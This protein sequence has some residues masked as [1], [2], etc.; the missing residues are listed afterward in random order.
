MDGALRCLAPHRILRLLNAGLSSS[1]VAHVT[2]GFGLALA[3][4]VSTAHATVSS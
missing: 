1:Q 4:A 3:H 2:V